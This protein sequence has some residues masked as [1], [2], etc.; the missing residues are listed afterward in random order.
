MIPVSYFENVT[1]LTGQDQSLEKI[2]KRIQGGTW[3]DLVTA[4]RELTGKEYDAKKRVAPA[5]T[6]S[7]RMI[8]RK[9]SVPLHDKIASRTGLICIDIDGKDNPDVD[10][11]DLWETCQACPWTRW[12]FKSFGGD[13]VKCIVQG[14]PTED[15][16]SQ[17]EVVKAWFKNEDITIDE[18]AKDLPRL[19]F[20]SYDPDLYTATTW[21]TIQVKKE[22]TLH[23]A[24]LPTDTT[25]EDVRELLSYIPSKPPYW[26]WVAISSAVFNTLPKEAAMDLLMEWS[27]E[28]VPG[29]YEKKYRGRLTRYH[30][31]TLY[32]HAVNHGF[33]ASQHV[34]RK[35][36]LGRFRVKDS[37]SKLPEPKHDEES[38]VV[39]ELDFQ[40][41]LQCLMEGQE[42]DADLFSVIHERDIRF[43]K[44]LNVWRLFQDNIWQEDESCLTEQ[45]AC[46]ELKN[47]YDDLVAQPEWN[48][49][50]DDQK[51]ALEKLIL[52]RH[53]K[54]NSYNY[55]SGTLQMAKRRLTVTASKLD[56]HSGLLCCEN[57]IYDF[58]SQTFTYEVDPALLITKKVNAYYHEAPMNCSGWRAFLYQ[59]HDGNMEM[60]NFLQ[61]CVGYWMTDFTD[62]DYLFFHYGSGA[63]GKSTFFQALQDILGPFAQ[64]MDVNLLTGKGQTGGQSDY[65]KAYLKG[66]RL[67]ITDELSN[68]SKLDGATIKA[69]I[70]GDSVAARLPFGKPF[71]FRPT[72]KIC[73]MGNHEPAVPDSD[74]GIW[75]RILKIPWTVQ[76]DP[77]KRK[78]RKHF[79]KMFRGER[80][81]ILQW[82]LEGWEEYKKQGLNPPEVVLQATK[83]YR[84]EEDQL[85]RFLE[86]R[87]D[88]FKPGFPTTQS[89]DLWKAYQ[90]WCHENGEYSAYKSSRA[91]IK[92]LQR[93]GHKVLRLSKNNTS[94][95]TISLINEEAG[96]WA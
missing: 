18:A 21:D 20:V 8:T 51:K 30:K 2:L 84:E 79:E 72:H 16:K 83:E 76:I 48:D 58:E 9:S 62:E 39:K 14:D 33:D 46:Q 64:V 88:C 92:Q 41:I 15:H 82:A 81:G 5:F 23:I 56:Q 31:G 3:Q 60:I 86:E 63:N 69:L 75:R 37:S 45:I 52:R 55:Q 40:F 74:Y 87:C 17:W 93:R 94:I 4:A 32:W 38:Y 61:R 28:D 54:L 11:Q 43:D 66:A 29:E 44:T 42:G 50:E 91:I 70:G 25:E 27:P 19:C 96:R 67:V 49:I 22:T 65:K 77:E 12:A 95:E 85:G 89:T 90:E 78:S 47:H 10:W 80:T 36:W 6:A 34:K 1:K 57:G 53:E 24:E 13:G 59:C 7:C 26:E 68:N 73:M 71:E 35:S